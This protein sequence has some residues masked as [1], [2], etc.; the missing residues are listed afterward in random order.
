MNRNQTGNMNTF[1]LLSLIFGI[2]GLVTMCCIYSAVVF[3]AL[4]ILFGFLSKGG[5]KR[6]CTQGY[7]GIALGAAAIIAAVLLTAFSFVSMIR[8]YG[9][10][11][12]AINST[13]TMLEETLNME[14]PDYDSIK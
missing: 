6:A 1:S 8:E 11:D 14:I 7:V 9:S 2:L 12:N 10:I 5:A 3:G 4:A 13:Y